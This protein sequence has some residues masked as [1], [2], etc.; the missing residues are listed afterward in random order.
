M[1]EETV[2][3][4]RTDVR[5]VSSVFFGDT[6]T[7][8][9]GN[10]TVQQACDTFLELPGWKKGQVWINNFNIGRFWHVGPQQTLYVP[11]PLLHVGENSI[12]V[13]EIHGSSDVA[14]A[15]VQFRDTP[16]LDRLDQ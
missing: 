14:T 15:T 3:A 2:F 10:F 6:P 7:F 12:V 4:I 13:L 9:K 8:Y 16:V 5:L 11:A 1:H